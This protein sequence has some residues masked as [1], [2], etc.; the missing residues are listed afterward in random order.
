[1]RPSPE[2]RGLLNERRAWPRFWRRWWR[3]L[4]AALVL[5]WWAGTRYIDHQLARIAIDAAY[6]AHPAVC[7]IEYPLHL[8]RG[9][10]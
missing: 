8:T 7:R 3:P 5:A 4:A 2:A 9:T 10:P 6:R 1:M